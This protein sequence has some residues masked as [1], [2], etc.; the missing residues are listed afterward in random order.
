MEDRVTCQYCG[1]EY[2]KKGIG[3]HIW[4]NH[5]SGI[6]HDPNKN[7]KKGTRTGWNKGLNEVVKLLNK[8]TKREK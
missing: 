3:T 7:Y 1:K 8:N 5:G 6:N 4:R 2:S